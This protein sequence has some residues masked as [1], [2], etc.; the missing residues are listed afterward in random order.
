MGD[1]FAHLS[2]PVQGVTDAN[3]R[4]AAP[5]HL[6]KYAKKLAKAQRQFQRCTKGSKRSAKHLLRIQRLNHKVS[7][8]RT[9]WLSELAT[10]LLGVFDTIVVENLTLAALAKRKKG[11]RFS[12]GA[13]IG[14]GAYGQFVELL[15]R[16]SLRIQGHNCGCCPLPFP[17]SKMCS[18]CGQ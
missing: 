17:S 18:G 6:S 7:A 10:T 5:R 11:Q 13:S 16:K 4:I 14:D 1:T 9:R 2:T 15:Q 3:G 12:F 8:E